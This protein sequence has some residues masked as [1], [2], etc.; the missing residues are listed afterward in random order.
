MRNRES[1]MAGGHMAL[2]GIGGIE[3][4]VHSVRLCWNTAHL[5]LLTSSPDLN[6]D[7]KGLTSLPPDSV[8]EKC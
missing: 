1:M 8:P 5:I 2:L 7:G 4:L 6:S 3:R